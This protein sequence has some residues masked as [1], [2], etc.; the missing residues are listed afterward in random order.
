[1]TINKNRKCASACL[2]MFRLFCN[3]EG[4]DAKP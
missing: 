4:L 1:M 3:N 2:D